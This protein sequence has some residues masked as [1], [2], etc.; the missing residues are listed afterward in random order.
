MTSFNHYALGSVAHF[1]HTV[2]GGLTPA[3]PG[4]KKIQIEP[5][6]GGTVNSA[7]THHL[8]PYGRVACIWNIEG[9]QMSVD[10]EV[11]PN[12]IAKVIL[13]GET[14]EVGSGMYHFEVKYKAD[15]RWP[16]KAQSSPLPDA[17]PQVDSFVP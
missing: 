9:S 4:W 10:I 13:P 5:R 15:P 16:P 14:K 17:G 3:E 6:P 7:N 11:P 2:I 12:T 1:L 8:T